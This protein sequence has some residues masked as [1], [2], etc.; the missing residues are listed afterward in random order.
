MMTPFQP[1]FYPPEAFNPA[2]IAREHSVSIEQAQRWV[3]EAKQD[4]VFRND[5]YQVALRDLGE[6]Y[7]LS[8][9]RID[10]EPIHDWRDLQ[11]IKN[12]LVSAECE[13]VE[14]YPAESRRVDSANQYHL[15]VFKDPTLRIPLGFTERLV[16]E[17]P[18]GQ[19]KQRPFEV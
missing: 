3:R 7:H 18:G 19:A 1:A 5:K 8:I 9:K 13:G 14:L 4:R 17:S 10:R 15:W 6:V 11:E 2:F 16:T 12:R